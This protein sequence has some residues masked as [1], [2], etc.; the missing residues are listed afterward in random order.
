MNNFSSC[1]RKIAIEKLKSFDFTGGS[2]IT[3]VVPLKCFICSLTKHDGGL[4]FGTNGLKACRYKY[5]I[6]L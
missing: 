3:N 1:C 4:K 6:K 5:T 2:W